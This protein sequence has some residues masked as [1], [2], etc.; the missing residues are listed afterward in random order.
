MNRVPN[1]QG[2]YRHQSSKY[3]IQKDGLPKS[4]KRPEWSDGADPF[5]EA[6]K[7]ALREADGRI[8]ALALHIG[9]GSRLP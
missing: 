8:I 4:T 3:Q 1:I 5:K 6:D 9:D 7:K 2:K